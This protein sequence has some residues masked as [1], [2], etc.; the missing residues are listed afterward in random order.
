VKVVLVQSLADSVVADL[1]TA[2]HKAALGEGHD[3]TVCDLAA[4]GFV[5]WMSA[6]DRH[7]YEGDHPLVD[8]LAATYAA[9]IARADVIV[10]V[11]RAQLST[12]SPALKGWLEKVLVP[13]VAFVLDERT[14]RVKRGLTG[15][16]KI[17]GISI[18][19]GLGRNG[20]NTIMRA[21]R[22]CTG[23][24]TRAT[25]LELAPGGDLGAFTCSVERRMASL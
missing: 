17:V 9:A 12:V 13:G 7:A 8:P 19:D 14:R 21:F 25:W 20:R 16:K 4:D 15:V 3:V 22:M 5:P 1:A 18:G 2:V 6:L 23:W 24:R 11:D 10:F